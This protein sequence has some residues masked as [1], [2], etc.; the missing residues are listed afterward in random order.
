[1]KLLVCGGRDFTDQEWLFTHLDKIHDE[2]TIT[3]IIEGGQRTYDEKLQR[4]VGG[5]D[6]LANRWAYL[7]GVECKT[8][9]A[10]WKIHHKR[11]G[12]IRNQLMLTKYKPDRV[13]SAPGGNGTAHMVSIARAAGV[14]V[15]KPN[16]GGFFGN[17]SPVENQN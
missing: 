5:A 3:L 1:M 8:E 9:K 11:A 4:N 7:N 14:P 2:E 16:Y 12:L 17:L 15:I 13:F 10:R 6:F